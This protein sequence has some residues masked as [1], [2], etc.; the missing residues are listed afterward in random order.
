[1]RYSSGRENLIVEEITLSL[2]IGTPAAEVLD[3]WI[4]AV[5]AR[6]GTQRGASFYLGIAPATISRRLN[7]RR[8]QGPEGKRK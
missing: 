4:S 8:R 6:V 7:H 1:M 3:R 5:V 2:P